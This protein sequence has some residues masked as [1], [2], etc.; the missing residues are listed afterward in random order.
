[1]R[2]ALLQYEAGRSKEESRRAIERLLERYEGKPD[3]I[4]LPEY[5]PL[6]PTGMKAPELWEQA[7]ELRG[8]WVK[9][10]GSIA[11]RMSSCLVG[12]LVEK[13]P[14]PP[15]VYNTAVL[16]DRQG[17]VIGVYRKTHLFDALG[18]RESSIMVPGEELF[19]PQEACGARIGLAIC[20]EIRY[21]E[22][23]RSQALR[24]A[25]LA[26]V[27]TAWYRG[28]LKEETLTVL[29]RA[30]AIENGIFLA[31]PVQYGHNFTGRSMVVDPNGVVVAEGGV[32]EKVVE[33]TIDLGEVER[34]R[35]RAPLLKLGRWELLLSGYSGSSSY[36]R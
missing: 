15:K 9:F 13:S 32:G 25:Q 1:M 27:P 33:T 30:R 20:F 29:A 35:E 2:L 24:G 36:V 18:Y 26:V 17:E 31:L 34:V 4:A 8:E 3:L 5:S 21:P 16:L 6:D 11:Q 7:E 28:P 12:S 19:Q 22:I 10:L 23:F 14:Y